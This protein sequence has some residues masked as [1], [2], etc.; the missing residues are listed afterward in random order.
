[1]EN[2]KAFNKGFD[3]GRKYNEDLINQLTENLQILM[4][5]DEGQRE[6]QR[7]MILEYK[8][9]LASSSTRRRYMNSILDTLKLESRDTISFLLNSLESIYIEERNLSNILIEMNSF[10]FQ[11]QAKALQIEMDQCFIIQERI[12]KLLQKIENENEN[13]FYD[14]KKADTISLNIPKYDG[15]NEDTNIYEHLL[16]VEDYI[17]LSKSRGIS[18]LILKTSLTGV[19]KDRMHRV[20]KVDLNPS[21]EIIKAELIKH[22]GDVRIIINSYL[23]K[24]RKIGKL[25]EDIRINVEDSLKTINAHLSIIDSCAVMF[26]LTPNDNNS[27]YRML[28]YVDAIESYLPMTYCMELSLSSKEYP[29]EKRFEL[30]HDTFKEIQKRTL[31]HFKFQTSEISRKKYEKGLPPTFVSEVKNPYSYED[32]PK[33]TCPICTHMESKFNSKPHTTKHLV[34]KDSK[35]TNVLIESCSFLVNLTVSEKSEF[36]TKIGFCRICAYKPV[37]KKHAEGLCKFTE[38]YVELK[39]K[40]TNCNQRASFCTV[41]RSLNKG[42]LRYTKNLLR[43]FGIEYR[44]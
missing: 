31:K 16:R 8:K 3:Q 12:K 2:E 13:I 22:F 44:F 34:T 35:R 32:V 41:H 30:T 24:H 27:K 18:G 6:G 15:S 21:Y 10:G 39:C 37:S 38:K 26:K 23:I 29:I 42:K 33:G 7:K 36:L 19:A 5:N 11:E 40:A 25:A 1:M 43:K 20:F 17:S 28:T 9:A 14:V 4:T